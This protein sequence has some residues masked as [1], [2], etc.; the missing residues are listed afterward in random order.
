MRL[1]GIK[2]QKIS[3]K[4]NRKVVCRDGY[5]NFEIIPFTPDT[6]YLYRPIDSKYICQIRTERD[7]GALWAV[8]D[9][10]GFALG[11]CPNNKY[12]QSRF[13]G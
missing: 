6:E 9:W 2:L 7:R 8:T 4:S 10:G 13:Y 1:L 3:D 11:G 5:V 12:Q